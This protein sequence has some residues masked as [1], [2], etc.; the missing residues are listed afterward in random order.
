ELWDRQV[1]DASDGDP[2]KCSLP[3]PLHERREPRTKFEARCLRERQ[4]GLQV[5][6]HH[7]SALQKRVAGNRLV[8]WQAAQGQPACADRGLLHELG[9]ALL[10]AVRRA[11]LYEPGS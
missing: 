4:F 10:V 6:W 7:Q 3:V 11:L 5:L 1:T 9:G 2:E 8:A